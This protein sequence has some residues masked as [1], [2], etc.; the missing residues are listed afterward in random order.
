[1]QTKLNARHRLLQTSPTTKLQYRPV[2]TTHQYNL[3]ETSRAKP[4]LCP[5]SKDRVLRVQT[6]LQI[7]TLF[8]PRE[9]LLDLLLL[10]SAS[11]QWLEITNDPSTNRH[12]G[13]EQIRRSMLGHQ[14][15]PLVQTSI[16]RLVWS[17]T[18]E[19]GVDRLVTSTARFVTNKDRFV[20]SPDRYGLHL[21]KYEDYKQGLVWSCGDNLG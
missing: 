17:G 5:D 14:R 11:L 7:F 6:E 18:V 12:Q 20:T 15:G 10:D 8:G 21:L 9:A 2:Q 16:D 1:M 3:A 19:N 13:E 4:K